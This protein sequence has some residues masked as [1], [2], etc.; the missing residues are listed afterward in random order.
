[1]NFKTMMGFCSCTNCNNRA[2]KTLTI[3]N[4]LTRKTRKIRV[5]EDCAWEIEGEL[6]KKSLE[7]E[8]LQFR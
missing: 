2:T 1:M 7:K 6:W 4:R 3:F 5:C 8:S